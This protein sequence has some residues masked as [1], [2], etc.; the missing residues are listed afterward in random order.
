M[1][2]TIN[3]HVWSPFLS[4]AD[5][6]PHHDSARAGLWKA[7]GSDKPSSFSS[8][9]GPSGHPL[10]RY[11]PVQQCLEVNSISL[12]SIVY[13]S[14]AGNV[15]R[16]PSLSELLGSNWEGPWTALRAVLNTS[17]NCFIKHKRDQAT[18]LTQCPQ[19]PPFLSS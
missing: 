16:A 3:M 7:V 2:S 5:S 10:A 14:L 1:H 17:Q 19:R 6:G 15:L 9:P 13:I 18:S 11:D 12:S 8:K 4:E